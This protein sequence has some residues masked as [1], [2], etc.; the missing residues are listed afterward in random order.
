MALEELIDAPFLVVDELVHMSL[1][2]SC[3]D[4]SNTYHFP[5][6]VSVQ[7]VIALALQFLHREEQMSGSHRFI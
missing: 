7:Q 5:L 3:M 6:T 2:D 4:I 1:H